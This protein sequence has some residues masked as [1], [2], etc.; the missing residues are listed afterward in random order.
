MKNFFAAL[1]L[2]LLVSPVFADEAAPA[3]A[4]PAAAAPAAD[5]PA[6]APAP[7]P[8]AK[9][10]GMSDEA[11]IKKTFGE[12]S[13][14]WAAGDAAAIVSHFTKEASIIN[15][16]GQDAWNREDSQKVIAA[17]LDMMKGSTQTFDDF[18]FHSVLPGGFSL[19]DAT[20]T[21]SGLKN[22][23]GSPAADMQFHIYAAMANRGGKW[24][25][26]ALRPYAFV[27]TG[28]APAAAP[29]A[30]APAA[31]AAPPADATV[32]APAAPVAPPDASVP[33]APSTK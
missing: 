16:F 31:P 4:A 14:A 7:A 32:P 27:K 18:K 25:V 19:I 17:D 26:L 10:S 6:A 29:A 5:A 23:D 21:V 13:D 9:K 8:K 15:P 30:A 3:A 11:G 33:P 20:G 2:V 1:M 28:N 22:A 24:C 12:I